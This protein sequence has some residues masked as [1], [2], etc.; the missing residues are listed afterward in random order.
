MRAVGRSAALAS[1]LVLIL[2]AGPLSAAPAEAAVKV[3]RQASSYALD[4]YFSPST[5]TVGRGGTVTWVFPAST[6]TATDD[7]GLDL[8]DSDLVHPDNPPP[9]YSYSF[10]AAGTYKFV[11]TL[12][13]GMD[14]RVRVP[15]RISPGS[16]SRGDDVVVTWASE[17]AQ[18]G[19]VYDVQIQKKGHAWR[20]WQDAVSI[21]TA[22]YTTVFKGTYRF[23]ARLR[24]L[25]TGAASQWSK[26]SKVKVGQGQS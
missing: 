3:P 24:S 14:G 5:I 26:A 13:V 10:P 17:D 4:D 7:S 9:T 22:I 25:G 2:G 8:Y 20:S 1:G 21:R 15:V 12:H 23:R 16:A 19:F 18:S 6:H 11:C